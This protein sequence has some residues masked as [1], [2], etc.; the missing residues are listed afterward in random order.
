M[1]GRIVPVACQTIQLHYIHQHRVVQRLLLI[2]YSWP[3]AVR[4]DPPELLAPIHRLPRARTPCAHQRLLWPARATPPDASQLHKLGQISHLSL[5]ALRRSGT[6]P[7]FP[8]VARLYRH[9]ERASAAPAHRGPQRSARGD[10]RRARTASA[11]FRPATARRSRRGRG[12]R[13]GR[14]HRACGGERCHATDRAH[15]GLPEDLDPDLSAIDVQPGSALEEPESA[16]LR[17]LLIEQLARAL[18]EL[19]AAQREV[20][21]AH[22]IEG[23]SFK[24]LAAATGLR[25]NT[26]L[27]REHA[28]VRHLRRRLRD[29]R[30]LIQS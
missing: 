28:A 19:P 23:V 30:D 20:F 5:A 16:H 7:I 11:R 3:R 15:R 17:E 8:R 26:L 4:G 27:G 29:I 10:D 25:I 14:L 18:D 12:H 6:P 9:G 13:P 1:I 2:V 21:L 22:E 24:E